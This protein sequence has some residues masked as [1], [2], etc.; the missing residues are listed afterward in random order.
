MTDRTAR[1]L[2]NVALVQ[3]IFA[4]ANARTPNATVLNNAEGE[5]QTALVERA[6]QSTFDLR[7]A[8]LRATGRPSAD[9]DGAW[10]TAERTPAE[11]RC[12]LRIKLVGDGCHVCNPEP[13]AESEGSPNGLLSDGARG[14]AYEA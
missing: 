8:F 1:Q 13:W 11:C 12:S 5:A 7:D 10:Q 9:V 4:G 14:K 2:A 3:R 6:R